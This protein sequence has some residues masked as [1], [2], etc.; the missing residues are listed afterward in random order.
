[1]KSAIVDRGFLLWITLSLVSHGAAVLLAT[2]ESDSFV[3]FIISGFVFLTFSVHR[4][5]RFYKAQKTSA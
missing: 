1:M 5:D 3:Y 2:R 4:A